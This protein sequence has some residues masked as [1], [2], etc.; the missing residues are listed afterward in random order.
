MEG[1][2]IDVSKIYNIIGKQQNEPVSLQDLKIAAQKLGFVA[3]GYR[4]KMTDLTN[5]QGVAI[6]AM[7]KASGTQGDP[8]HYILVKSVE[9][10]GVVVIDSRK[11]QQLI[12][13]KKAFESQWSGYVLSIT[14]TDKNGRVQKLKSTASPKDSRFDEV[15]DVGVVNYGAKIRRTFI[16]QG[17]AEKGWEISLAKRS[18]TCLESTIGKNKE[19]KRTLTLAMH[20]LDA[21]RRQVYVMIRLKSPQGEESYRS[22]AI[23][24]FVRNTSRIIPQKAYISLKD[25]AKYEVKVEWFGAKGSGVEFHG[26]KSNIPGL[27]IQ[28]ISASR[29]K[30]KDDL[31]RQVFTCVV[32]ASAVKKNEADVNGQVIFTL[33]TTEREVEIP[34][35]VVLEGSELSYSYYPKIALFLCPSNTEKNIRKIVRISFID[36]APLP[37]QCVVSCDKELP[38]VVHL[39]GQDKIL[40]VEIDVPVTV[41]KRLALTP[42]KG[43]VTVKTDK[44][45]VLAKIPVTVMAENP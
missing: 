11:Y 10:D 16:I 7:G 38:V 4:W 43:Y 44:N 25:I 12:I 32:D 40:D 22:Y 39:S 31:Y 33:R 8:F 42:L 2:R 9:G 29:T 34:M 35:E 30:I 41:F 23:K 21:G 14:S 3:E 45:I 13:S 36:K 15:A 20:A 24:A 1:S 37:E 27:G 19:G 17:V 28:L 18:C 5:M 26:A 6:V